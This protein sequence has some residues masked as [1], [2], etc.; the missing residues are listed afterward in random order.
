MS[1]KALKALSESLGHDFQN[2]ELLRE[3]LRHPSYTHENPRAGN[4]NQRLEFL[5]DAVLG[6]VVAEALIKRFP[7]AREGQLTRWRAA[8]VS[9][10]PL[11]RA[12][13]RVGL[14]V[15]LALGRGE[16]AGGGRERPSLLCDAFEA[17]VG[18]SFLDG[19][20]DA[21]RVVVEI[22]LGQQL[23]RICSEET[24]D[25]KSRLQ[26]RIQASFAMPP[27][28]EVVNMTGPDHDKR[29][30]VH[31]RVNDSVLGTGFG[32]SKKTAEQN[33]AREALERLEEEAST[34]EST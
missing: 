26:E 16:E 2:V 13:Q 23:D 9:E 11:A 31:I 18:A 6:L 30:E 8:L 21:S 14:G 28:Y 27:T 29:F 19:G 25:H 32:T 12:A 34:D 10:K 15:Q 5:G 4:H 17:A 22:V 20:L 24:I 1:Q 33:A 3:A 7:E